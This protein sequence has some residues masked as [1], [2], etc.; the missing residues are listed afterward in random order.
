MRRRK[1]SKL[2]NENFVADPHQQTALNDVRDR[3][4]GHLRGCG[5]RRLWDRSDPSAK[6]WRWPLMAPSCRGHFRETGRVTEGYRL[7][8]DR[9]PLVQGFRGRP[10]RATSEGKRAPHPRQARRA[11]CRSP[12]SRIVPAREA[13]ATGARRRRLDL[14]VRASPSLPHFAADAGVPPVAPYPAAR[15]VQ[16]DLASTN[17]ARQASLDSVFLAGFIPRLQFEVR[18]GGWRAAERERD[19]VVKFEIGQKLFGK[20]QLTNELD[21]DARGISSGWPNGLRPARNAD[22]LV[23]G[24]LRDG[25]IDR[26]VLSGRSR[27]EHQEQDQQVGCSHFAEFAFGLP[28]SIAL[29][30]AFAASSAPAFGPSAL[31]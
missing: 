15:F 13:C 5:D 10:F 26:Q 1:T 11:S 31:Q 22:C 21:L 27:G 14:L 20:L 18:R 16:S 6:S 29:R 12:A 3:L 17:G 23:D 2:P 19:S 4:I 8:V 7:M 30:P 9:Q 24:R 25:G 28:A